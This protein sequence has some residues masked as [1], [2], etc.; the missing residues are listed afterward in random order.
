MY[1]KAFAYQVLAGSDEILHF[2][3]SFE[4]VHDAALEQRSE[5][6]AAGELSPDQLGAMAIYECDMRLPEPQDVLDALNV[7]D[8][9]MVLL[10]A[11][12]VQKRVIHL[13]VG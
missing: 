13:V 11:C 2:G 10:D 8:E 5:L 6:V 9:P 1:Y 12:L 7:R 4:D 3:P